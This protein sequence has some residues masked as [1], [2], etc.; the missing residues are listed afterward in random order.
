MSVWAG[1]GWALL[2]ILGLFFLLLVCPVFFRISF[3]GELIV[4][5][6]VLGIPFTIAAP[7]KKDKTEENER[8]K[9]KRKSAP[10]KSARAGKK[11]SGFSIK[12]MLKEDG[13]GTVIA[14]FAAIS[15][16]AAT[17]LRRVLAAVRFSR[18]RVELLIASADAAKTAQD[19]GKACGAV[20]PA[21]AVLQHLTHMK[22]HYVT[23]TPDFLSEKGRVDLEI[24]LHV[25]PVRILWAALRLL[26]G[27]LMLNLLEK[28]DTRETSVPSG[29]AVSTAK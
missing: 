21:L 27:Y 1:I 10:K 12:E 25:V 5:T 13:P 24:R 28:D 20:Y 9:G 7:W 16:L 8:V 22:R 29:K 2:G 6:Y 3:H 17:A 18:F 15:R 4:R 23:V 14:Y 26:W 11:K 19:V